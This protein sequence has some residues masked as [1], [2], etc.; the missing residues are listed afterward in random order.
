MAAALLA[1]GSPPP[2]PRWESLTR[3]TCGGLLL[4]AYV[5]FPSGLMQRS[6]LVHPIQL[7]AQT[8][9]ELPV[10]LREGLTETIIYLR[11]DL[12]GE[13]LYYRLVTNA[14]SMSAT[15]LSAQRY[16]K[17]FVYLPVA[18]HPHPRRALLLCYGVGSTAKALTNTKSF[19]TIDVVEISQDILEMNRVVYPASTDRPLADPRVSVHIEDGRFFLQTTDRRFDLITGEPPPP[20]HA[21]V[22]ALYTREYFKLMWN[23]LADSGIVTYWF[24]ANSLLEEDGKRIIRAFC[25]VFADCSLWH[26]SGFDWILMGTRD[27]QGPV[28]E[29]S[30][31]RQWH[32]PVVGPELRALGLEVPEQLGALF[33]ADA[34]TL[35][36]ITQGTK[37]LSDNYPKRLSNTIPRRTQSQSV[38]RPWMDVNTAQARFLQS[39]SVAHLWSESLRRASLPY[40]AIQDTINHMLPG[41]PRLDVVANL[42]LLHQVLTRSTLRTFALWLLGSGASEQQATSAAAA[43]GWRDPDLDYHLGAGALADRDYIHAEARFQAGQKQQATRREF[44]YLRIYALCMAG[45]REE[46]HQLVARSGLRQGRDENDRFFLRFLSDTFALDG[47]HG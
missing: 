5:F 19:E 28:T 30:F 47:P 20:K 40:F 15:S 18:L 14:Y 16:M 12:F 37:P 27:L 11:R 31:T 3:Y 32:D 36:E 22:V 23:R 10:A 6:Y 39:R 4:L 1:F 46:A 29:E 8:G 38:Y 34:D 44:L 42:P 21:G 43:K 35:H 9:G 7:F 2:T 26:G 45:R 24:P 25:D 41:E 13:P 17:L 33:M